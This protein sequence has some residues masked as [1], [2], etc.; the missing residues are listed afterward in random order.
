MGLAAEP[1]I[2]QAAGPIAGR[3]TNH[4][5]FSD[6]GSELP[7]AMPTKVLQAHLV[8]SGLSGPILVDPN[9]GSRPRYWGSVWAATAGRSLAPS[10]LRQALA[11]IDALYVFTET[12]LALSLDE[13]LGGLD[14]DKIESILVA[15]HSYTQNRASRAHL[16]SSQNWTRS[17]SF[18]D[19]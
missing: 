13:V 6:F 2:A 10:T 1:P 8:P 18:V 14:F 19:V 3:C 11:A 9:H 7:T 16:K 17:L 12:S 4:D 15:F 5:A